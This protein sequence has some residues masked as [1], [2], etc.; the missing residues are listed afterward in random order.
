[1]LVAR[2]SLVRPF[3]ASSCRGLWDRG[4]RFAFS[5]LLWLRPS[6][7]GQCQDAPR[8]RRDWINRLTSITIFHKLRTREE[9]RRE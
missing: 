6:V 4:R 2:V 8:E 7:W 1:M 9:K 5:R 3:R